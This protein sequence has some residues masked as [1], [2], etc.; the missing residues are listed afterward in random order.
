L[1][2]SREGTDSFSF[3]EDQDPFRCPEE[4]SNRET[5]PSHQASSTDDILSAE[6]IS[7]KP[8]L[9]LTLVDDPLMKPSDGLKES[10]PLLMTLQSSLPVCSSSFPLS[11]PLPTPMD[12]TS[13]SNPKEFKVPPHLRHIY[14][15]GTALEDSL[16]ISQ[17]TVDPAQDIYALT[18][19]SDENI[20]P[21]SSKESPT[22]I[23]DG[24]NPN[25]TSLRCMGP[26]ERRGGEE[27][28]WGERVIDTYNAAE[29][30]IIESQSSTPK[31]GCDQNVIADTY[32]LANISGDCAVSQPTNAEPTSLDMDEWDDK[33][34]STQFNQYST[35]IAREIVY[36]TY[37]ITRAGT[38][39]SDDHEAHSETKEA[40][41]PSQNPY[42]LLSSSGDDNS[43]PEAPLF[44]NR[45]GIVPFAQHK[46]QIRAHGLSHGVMSMHRDAGG[47]EV[48]N[49]LS[50]CSAPSSQSTAACHIDATLRDSPLA[51][52]PLYYQRSGTLIDD[53]S[54]PIGKS[55]QEDKLKAHRGFALGLVTTS[56]ILFPSYDHISRTPTI[57]SS[58][59]IES[60][61][62]QLEEVIEK[63]GAIVQDSYNY[64]YST[65][66]EDISRTG[67]SFLYGAGIDSA[68]RR[69]NGRP[70]SSYKAL[71]TPL[72]VP[73]YNP[74]VS[75]ISLTNKGNNSQEGSSS[76]SQEYLD[77]RFLQYSYPQSPL[78]LV[79]G[80]VS[81]EEEVVE[82]VV[83]AG[84]EQ[85]HGETQARE[86]LPSPE[87][88]LRPVRVCA[89]AVGREPNRLLLG[90]LFDAPSEDNEKQTRC[91]SPQDSLGDVE[92]L[93]PNAVHGEMPSWAQSVVSLSILFDL[94]CI[95]LLF[96]CSMISKP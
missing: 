78:S 9:P 76:G 7:L 81:V 54:I 24:V 32:I 63:R 94:I 62:Q 23:C 72:Q 95:A 2:S 29:D 1:L 8:H 92:S 86:G 16:L 55:P 27:G 50:D 93:K 51:D 30:S 31:S 84:L 39:L 73:S 56:D 36:D 71:K 3:A 53:A 42:D 26:P 44:L 20:L 49:T 15:Q 22:K 57:V 59:S 96:R 88:S 79:V 43:N 14:T 28:G 64:T 58:S 60:A 82:E 61:P 10:I 12:Q 75:E 19:S 38:L 37:E 13:T 21:Y 70:V 83:E 4:D 45:I 6:I 66:P 47:R 41:S 65:Q 25:S 91:N 40:G 69:H 89:N 48:P 85:C 77:G 52:Q 87:I 67:V 35:E 18:C 11:F 46:N 74:Q 33:P 90:A 34:R 17:R 5:D 80:S 68:E